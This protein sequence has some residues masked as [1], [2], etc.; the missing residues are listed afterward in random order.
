MTDRGPAPSKYSMPPTLGYMNHDVRKEKKPAY[1][2][3]LRVDRNVT[4]IG[5]GPAKYAL[6]DY[7][8][9][10]RSK[11]LSHTFGKRYE[12]DACTGLN[13]TPASNA[14]MSPSTRDCFPSG[15]FVTRLHTFN[16]N[17]S[18]ES[19]EVHTPPL[20]IESSFS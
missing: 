3:G 10:G 17:Q 14:Y 4:N 13:S 20:S 16:K 6:A 2:F 9:F 18:T 11:R 7:T 1:S 19:T 5:P 8:R 15:S 12:S